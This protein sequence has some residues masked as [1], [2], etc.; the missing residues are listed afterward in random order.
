MDLATFGCR[1][2]ALKPP[3]HQHKPSLAGRGLEG[4][5]FGRS[6]DSK[7]CYDVL[8]GTGA[9]AKIIR[10]SSVV[11]DEEWMPLHAIGKQHRPLTSLSHAARQPQ[12]PGLRPDLPSAS[13]VANPSLDGEPLRLG[14]LFSGPHSRADGLPPHLKS[15]GWSHIELLGNNEL[16]DGWAHDLLND[17]TYAEYLL[18]AKSGHF[19]AILTAFPCAAPSVTL[20]TKEFPDGLPLDQIDPK[21]HEELR[22]S[23]LLLDRVANIL[24]AARS[25]PK[26]TTLIFEHPADRSIIDA[27]CHAPEFKD[28]G[29][30]LATS[31]FKRLIAAADLTANRTFAYCR[32]GSPYQKYTTLYYTP[33]AGSVLDELGE[34]D[35][36]CNHE[37]GKHSQQNGGLGPQ[38]EFVSTAAAAYPTELCSILARALTIA[39][40]G[41]T[42]VSAPTAAPVAPLGP[43]SLPHAAR[44]IR[45]PWQPDAP[46]SITSPAPSA[47][48]SVSE[49]PP[50]SPSNPVRRLDFLDTASPRK[51]LSPAPVTTNASPQWNLAG[52]GA[53]AALREHER[54]RLPP[55]RPLSRASNSARWPATIPETLAPI[56]ES[57]TAEDSY[58]P[59]EPPFSAAAARLELS[60]ARAALHAYL[61]DLAARLDE[62]T[63]VPRA[64]PPN[65][66]LGASLEA[67]VAETLYD[68]HQ[69]RPD[70]HTFE[71]PISAWRTVSKVPFAKSV[72][73]HALSLEIALDDVDLKSPDNIIDGIRASFLTALRADSPDAPATHA[74]AV[75]RGD[76]WMRAE[77]KEM[78]NHE[79]NK[80][81]TFIRRA[82]V[83]AG[84]RIHRLIWVYKVKRDGT[85]KARLCVQ[86]STLEAGVDYDQ[87]FSAAL[88]YSSARSLFAFAAKTGC[89]VRS[90]DL[91]AAYLQGEFLDGE[92]VFCH[93]AQGY[94]KYD[95][96]GEPMIARVDKPIYGI[97]QAGRRLQRK[98]FEWLRAQGFKALDDSDPCVFKL[99]CTDGEIL[100]IGVY[101]DNLQVVHSVSIGADGRGPAGCA[102]NAFLDALQRDWAVTDEGPMEDLLGIE[103]EHYQDGSIKLHQM[104]YINKLVERFLPNGPSPRVQK[105][106]MPYSPLFETRMKDALAL[107]AGAHPDI[108]TTFQQRVG[109]LMYA[110]TSTRPDIAY[111]VHQLC[112]CLQRPTPE[113]LLETEHLL[114]YLARHASVGLTYT[115][116]RGSLHAFADASWETRYSTSGWVVLWQSAALSWGSRGQNC[117]ALS[118]C[119]A[120]IIALSEAT[121]DVIYHR[122]L[123]AG[124]DAPIDGPTSLSTDSK[125]A[126]DVSYNPEHHDRMKHV[127]RRH[128][129]VRDMV[130]SFEIEVPFVPTDM[131]P[132][133]F[134]TK[135]IRSAAKFFSFRRQV[136]N[137]PLTV[138]PP[139]STEGGRQ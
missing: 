130:E 32:L 13:A 101:V 89:C 22:L 82:D 33:E 9:T 90:I 136:M 115:R 117:V 121:K 34:P 129:Y 1:A 125:S 106:T 47:A 95:K 128:F 70:A 8:V 48:S 139:P 5:F 49:Q 21:L 105:N 72:G 58:D 41:R 79:N 133:D 43:N 120:E 98:L 122:K 31:P 86:G 51:V 45:D 27:L 56:P 138:S 94:A 63:I 107:D 57:P 103:V 37:L 88:R 12:H 25:S 87:V 67:A 66:S 24:I 132:A 54:E 69:R 28:H 53:S 111:P 96:N 135:P 11:I 118:T 97:Q 35:Y 83:P 3:Q 93:A 6:L 15:R 123:L 4:A 14:L 42:S 64:A 65:P 38:G 75:K 78:A 36:Q 26:R 74:E 100:T 119:E 81:W 127:A 71:V 108:L 39:R 131:N 76:V 55:R 124:I 109:C 73:E 18:K 68:A 29:S 23:N 91:I 19:D 116:A 112:K 2:F 10:S 126:R 7:G 17:S 84:R 20:R 113:L 50:G 99:V 44:T 92:V 85:C 46:T 77:G 52:Q 61:D 30:I 110:T 62:A 59:Y 60:G 16:G 134:F 40:T 137:E 102:Y 114:S 80:S 104:K